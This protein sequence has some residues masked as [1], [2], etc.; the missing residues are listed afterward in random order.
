MPQVYDKNDLFWTS[1]GDY[2]IAEGDISDTYQDPL[3]SLVQEIRTRVEADLGDWK[4]FDSVGANIRDMIGER[5]R[6]QIAELLRTRIIG[7]LT[8]DGFINSRDISIRYLP[9]SHDKLMMRISIKVA[10]TA[11][12]AGSDTLRL[13]FIY[14]YSDNNVFFVGG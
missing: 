1:R 4:V 7:A 9:L 13:G 10:P 5:N 2:R 12:N 3:R 11:R 14:N 8:R 6:P